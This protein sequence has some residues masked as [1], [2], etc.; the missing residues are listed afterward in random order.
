MQT[1]LL[2]VLS[3][4]LCLGS[5][6]IAED[7]PQ[8]RGPT[9]QGHATAKDLPISWNETEN[10]AWKT[11]VP[12]KG[13]SSPV[14]LGDQIWLTTA[15][16]TPEDES[17]A[18]ERLKANTGNQPLVLCAEATFHALC[19][20]KKTGTILH[21]IKL[22]SEK[23]PQWVHAQNSYA[24]PTPILENGRVYCHFG[25]HGTICLDAKTGKTLWENHEHRINHE[26]GPGGSPV[27]HDDMLI[28]H[29]DGS[30]VQ[31]LTALDKNSGKTKWRT[32]RSGA[33]NSNPQLKKAYGTPLVVELHG[34]FV[35]LSPAADWLYAYEPSTGRELWK[36]NYQVLG[37]SIVP[38]P[39]MSEGVLYLCTS[40]MK[41]ELLAIRLDGADGN[42]EPH[43]L[44]REK[45]S[46]PTQPSPLVVGNE[47]YVVSD[48]GGIL[49]CFDKLTGKENYRER[50]EGKHCSSP[51]FADGK[52]YLCDREGVT[53]VV[54]PGP[55]FAA[56]GK[57]KLDGSIMASPAAV[58][59]ALFIRTEHAMYRIEKP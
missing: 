28:F 4:L 52:I 39:V 15:F 25:T 46:I 55:K 6:L 18:K 54:A 22:F 34:Q 30:D 19:L 36:L 21:N 27:L 7:W 45:K 50:I 10:V 37:F 35:L 44:W 26:N 56:L 23:E 13:W 57:N 16:E 2:F 5:V 14:I 8:F 40:F 11:A 51:L 42:P 12:G 53:V 47:V 58:D 38:R 49:S 1:R 17:K 20:D 48:Q 59:N 33:M 32:E 31:Y 3:L 9:G 43:I 41:S 24:S 29:C